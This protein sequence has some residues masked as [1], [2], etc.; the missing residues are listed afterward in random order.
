MSLYLGSSKFKELYLGSNKIKEAYLGS[1]K[2]YSSLPYKT[3]KIG[4]QIWMAESLAEEDGGS[5]VTKWEMGEYYGHAAGTRYVYTLDAA[6]RISSK[7]DSL[8]FHIPTRA[9]AEQLFNYVGGT[10]IAGKKLKA[11]VGWYNNSNGTDDYGFTFYA[12]RGPGY[13]GY[14]QSLSWFWTQTLDGLYQFSTSN[15]VKRESS[16]DRNWSVQV[17]LVKSST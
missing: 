1:N 15:S 12:A 7:Y 6:I 13:S 17:R 2:V 4:N 8:G 9:E 14:T 5:G 16:W 10:S 11:K 3:V